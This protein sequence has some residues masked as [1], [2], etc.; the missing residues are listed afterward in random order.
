MK[1]FFS[2]LLSA[3]MMFSLA[4]CSSDEADEA[5][6]STSTAEA[7]TEATAEAIT[8]E[9]A[10]ADDSIDTSSMTIAIAMQFDTL[11]PA[12]STTVYN[13]Y[14][15]Q[16]IYSG[17]L[18]LDDN[19]QPAPCMAESYEI[20]EDGL[21]WTFHLREDM[22]FTDGTPITSANFKFALERLLSYGNEN[23]FRS[24]TWVQFIQGAEEY[25]NNALEVG[26]DFDCL[27]ADDSELGVECP[28]DYTY[29]LKLNHPVSYMD[30]TVCGGGALSPLPLDTPQHDSTW[31]ITPGYATCGKYTL[32]EFSLNDKAVVK[33]SDSYFAANDVVME[34]LVW[35]VMA[36][37]SAQEAAFK[38]GDIDVALNVSS[39]TINTYL[40]TDNLWTL[41]YPATYS[42]IVNAGPT[43]P[44]Y[45][46]NE[47]VRKALYRAINKEALV[48]VVGGTD[49][50]PILEGYVAFGLPGIDGDFRTERDAEGY[51]LT[52]DPEVSAELLKAEGYTEENPLH[53]TYKYSMNS[54][55]GDIA[56]MLQAM[57]KA[58]GDEN[59]DG[60]GLIDVEFDAV[61]GGV[62][63]NEIDE[64][65]V[66]MGRYGLQVSDSPMTLLKNWTTAQQVTQMLPEGLQE[67]YDKMIDDAGYLT[68]QKE[69]A[70]ALHDAEDW[71]VQEHCLQWPLFQF[72]S[73]GLVQ[74]N[75]HGQMLKLS[76]LDF[77]K[78]YKDAE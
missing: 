33:K 10:A 26:A 5:T 30:V 40:G 60:V 67:E 38:T 49:L 39:D 57:W 52:Y 53:V 62:Y 8:A 34:E 73:S 54:I 41:M 59:G 6:A 77:S 24:S 32:E 14:V 17:L 21:A 31:S 27:T 72:A 46:Q 3:A 61:E 64:G 65:Q 48:S 51:E 1:K 18:E 68:D 4:A 70:Q 58:V 16:S 37:Q 19:A 43:G 12:L 9:E 75:L 71:L 25:R 23:A 13:G 74:S 42:I 28:D 7:T 63:Y 36:D 22:V 56:T 69:F 66:E 55:H 11:D 45:M 29:V 20:S 44:E 2:V 47:N 35:Q 15:I 76:T 78:C 50:Y